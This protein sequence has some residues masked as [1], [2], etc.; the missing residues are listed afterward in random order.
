MKPVAMIGALLLVAVLTLSASC[1]AAEYRAFDLGSLGSGYAEA[2]GVNEAGQVA[3]TS[4]EQG[5]I[6]LSAYRWSGSSGMMN[7]GALDTWGSTAT[8]IGSSGTVVGYSP[9]GD[10]YHAFLWDAA[11]GMR[12]LGTLA[13]GFSLAYA[14]NDAGRAVGTSDGRAF[15]WSE[16]T[17]MTALEKPVGTS[18]AAAFAINNAGVVAGQTSLPNG[19]NAAIWDEGGTMHVIGK[20]LPEDQ[21]CYAYGI[22][23][24]GQAVGYS[25]HG[26]YPECGESDQAFLW[27]AA[28]GLRGLGVLPGYLQSHAYDINN[29]GQVVGYLLYGAQP[30]TGFVWDEAGGMSALPCLPGDNYSKA[31]AIN[32]QGWIV[33]ESGIAYGASHA[34]LWKPVPEPSSLLALGV[35]GVGTLGAA[36]RRRRHAHA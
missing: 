15:I 17:G 28:T 20:L 10:N 2:R 25:G 14:I 12:D 8:G 22:N 4:A 5:S 26:L 6:R 11:N 34:V 27:S 16:G 24:A 29:H 23:D 19:T 36:L 32:D 7:L 9:V 30:A 33:G 13:G 3:G 18:S 31:Y 1:A 35:G 21:Y